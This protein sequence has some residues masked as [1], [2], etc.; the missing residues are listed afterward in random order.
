MQRA[1]RYRGDRPRT[2]PLAGLLPA[3]V[4]AL[5]AAAPGDGE[6]PVAAVPEAPSAGVPAA[7]FQVR[8]TVTVVSG[9]NRLS[10]T[11]VLHG[12]VRAVEGGFE[13]SLIAFGDGE[14]EPEPLEEPVAGFLPLP[15]LHAEPAGRRAPQPRPD[16]VPESTEGAL[17]CPQV[18]DPAFLCSDGNL[19]ELLGLVSALSGLRLVTDLPPERLASPFAFEL[20]AGLPP[21]EAISRFAEQA[22]I[23]WEIDGELLR[24]SDATQAEEEAA[25]EFAD[26][27]PE[28]LTPMPEGADLA[29]EPVPDDDASDAPRLPVP[30][31][32]FEDLDGATLASWLAPLGTILAVAAEIPA[33][34][35]R[36]ARVMNPELP[37]AQWEAVWQDGRVS[38][39]G[40]AAVTHRLPPT[41][42][43][44]APLL[45]FPFD[46][47]A[48]FD[49][50]M[51]EGSFG[52]P[53]RATWRQEG[54][55]AAPWP[56][57][58]DVTRT[59][60]LAILAPES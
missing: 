56:G 39:E 44:R 41:G 43:P 14:G 48:Q 1:A 15:D 12:T 17:E 24:V 57:R 49:G 26:D 40:A 51:G 52:L 16:P 2:G 38:I 36:D 9:E 47:P 28:G 33:D 11:Y 3:V 18:P 42:L 32:G 50:E 8:E 21:E 13:V 37:V 45:L 19:G 29:M 59:W 55:L 54:A 31:P 25:E 5:A 23:T 46:A 60:Q 10:S 53:F 22:G 7:P 34:E 4:L 27:E 6:E 35:L 58:L 30:S 20:P